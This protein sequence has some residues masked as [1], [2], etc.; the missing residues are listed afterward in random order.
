VIY[1]HVPYDLDANLGRAYNTFLS[2]LAPDDWAIFID[3]DAMPTTGQWFRQ[4][5]ECIAFLPHAGAFVAMTN[6]IARPWQRTGD[7]DSNDI[8]VHRRFGAERLRIRTLWDVTD[9]RGFGGVMFA[10]SKAA[11]QE[12]GGFA[13][14][15]GCVDHSLHHA[16]RSVG[17]RI[18]MIEG[19]YVF[20]WRHFGAADPT[21]SHPKAPNCPCL[22]IRETSPTTRI[23]LPC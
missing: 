4:F 17:R 13:D 7:P 19:L 18:F 16:L 14:G 8:A 10:V 1:T 20:H 21:S 6:R 3:H 15:L 11:W 9:T 22:S 23:A 2:L 12:C 5:S